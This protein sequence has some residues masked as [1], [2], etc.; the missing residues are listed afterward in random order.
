MCA[1]R[2][3]G[4]FRKMGCSSAKS[5]QV[6]PQ[7]L[8]ALDYAT[9]IV[10][11]ASPTAPAAASNGITSAPSSLAGATTTGTSAATPAGTSAPSAEPRKPKKTLVKVA[12]DGNLAL[13]DELL[14]SGSNLEELG[15]WDNT[16]LLVACAY[17]Q[18][19][20]ALKLITHGA[21]VSARN[22]HDATPMHYAAVEGSESV[23]TALIEAARTTDGSEGVKNL[24]D[25]GNA[26]VYNR[27]LDTYSRRTPLCS[28]SES[29]FP[30][31]VNLL[32]E[33]GA[34][35]EGLTEEGQTPLW[36]ACR[37]SRFSVVKLLLQK[38]A[39]VCVKDK[40][41]VSVLGAATINS[42]EEVVLAL[43][44]HGA[45]DVNDTAGLPLRDAVKAGRRAVVEALLTNGA[46]VQPPDTAG[47]STPLHVACE[48]GDEYL[49]SLLV[50]SR[51]E[52]SLGDAAGKTA[53]DL[54][55]RRNLP[56]SHIVSLLSNPRSGSPGDGSTGATGGSSGS[57]RQADAADSGASGPG[58]PV[59]AAGSTAAS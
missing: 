17:A 8:A 50:R 36:L 39:Q 15:M 47:V 35:I 13:I 37:Q 49:V 32:L 19:E 9:S 45:G 2:S 58:R 28:A 16:P 54:L 34:D 4:A 52:P 27:H 33:A 57:A 51:A 55:R 11:G 22:E 14:K 48:R 21:K 23:M 5:V 43:L 53:F 26:K 40:Q 25:P 46:A 20:A 30:D 41:G 42:N 29:G 24:V 6:H 38:G 1:F 12:K 3:G 18:S 7:A 44:S 56:D 10:P 31:L 59:S